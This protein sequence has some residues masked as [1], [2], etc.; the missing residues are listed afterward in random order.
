MAFLL[1]FMGLAQTQLLAQSTYTT[2]FSLTENPISEGGQW[3]NG[4]TDGL[5]WSN[6]QTANG[7]A[8]GTQT[9]GG[10]NDSVAILKGPWPADQTVQAT[11]YDNA[12]SS[13][14]PEV[15]LWLRG[16]ISA[17]SI[18]GYEI[19][20]SADGSYQQIVRWNGPLNSFTY[21]ATTSL[22]SNLKTGDVLKATM[23][24]N[25]ITV[26]KNGVQV[27]RAT[28]NSYSSGSPG[29]GLY[30][31]SSIDGTDALW[32][33]SE[34]TAAGASST[35]QA[36]ATPTFNPAAG[37]YSSPQ[38]VAI[39]CSTPSNTIYYTTNG[40]T[41]THSSTA[42]SGFIGVS[43]TT[44]INAICTASGYSDSTVAS[45]AYVI[46]VSGGGG[47]GGGGGGTTAVSGQN[48]GVQSIGDIPRSLSFPSSVTAGNQ[49]IVAAHCYGNRAPLI[50][51]PTKSS[52]SALV[53]P[54][55]Q[56][57]TVNLRSQYY[58]GAKIYRAFVNAGGSLT[59][60]FSATNCNGGI[61][62][63]GEFHGITAVDAVVTNTGTGSTESSGNIATSAAGIVVT[64]SSENSTN[65]FSYLQSGSNIYRNSAGSSQFTGEFQYRV[66]PAAGTYS[67]TASTGN[68]WAWWALSVA[69][70]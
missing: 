65:N 58:F 26:Y 49:V 17:H 2:T 7:N 3:L 64:T 14:S 4:K 10:Y 16:T 44:T 28:D 38:N 56:D 66:T 68:N 54:F 42:Y 50:N 24:G 43:S 11:V 46:S 70:K 9:N 31:Q 18:K 15:E 45:A 6:I 21:V 63:M 32:G 53:S 13:G 57:G 29:I 1:L 23:V 25:V 60:S 19:N 67:L 41:P 27:N 62:M 8:I 59:L 30:H 5:D 22:P 12:S 55:T 51:P 33:F 36:A 37:T 47:G 61:V 20:F 39:S 48:V 34:F 35:T 69:Y 40:S 52:G